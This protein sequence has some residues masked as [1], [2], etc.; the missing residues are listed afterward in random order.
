[1]IGR[2]FDSGGYR[3]GFQGQEQD[4]ETGLV[5][6][7]YRMHD[8]R[9]GRF[10]AVD[11]LAPDYPWNSPYAFSENVVIDHVELE[12]LEKIF[13]QLAS[14]N[15]KSFINTWN[16]QCKTSLGKEMMSK[17]KKQ[18]K[19]NTIYYHY[20]SGSPIGF[21]DVFENYEEYENTMDGYTD[22]TSRKYGIDKELFKK[23]TAD[24]RK[25]AVIGIT[26]TTENLKAEVYDLNHEE[27]YFME[28]LDHD[29]IKGKNNKDHIK[30][31]GI[32]IVGENSLD[33]I[34]VENNLNKSKKGVVVEQFRQIKQLVD[35]FNEQERINNIANTLE[36]SESHY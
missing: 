16:I 5:N 26:E 30:Y 24:G 28:Y 6:Y 20:A 19:Y 33:D 36:T 22:R 2:T 3:Y 29:D 1:M 35:E 34:E 32:P 8:P 13:Y 18:K 25:A 12:G 23:A 15:D 4:D 7:K 21:V 31:Y 17:F 11:P 27:Y 14:G 10:F 9:I